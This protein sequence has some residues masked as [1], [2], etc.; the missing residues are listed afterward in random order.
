MTFGA[1]MS[2]AVIIWSF[3]EGSLCR[4]WTSPAHSHTNPVRKYRTNQHGTTR[5]IQI[6]FTV[7]PLNLSCL[8]HK[9][10]KIWEKRRFYTYKPSIFRT[11]LSSGF[12]QRIYPAGKSI[13]R[14]L[15]PIED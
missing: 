14:A 12:S 3:C 15:P 1:I 2:S 8:G 9:I 7:L 11:K 4:K 10:T 5:V 13:T 6:L